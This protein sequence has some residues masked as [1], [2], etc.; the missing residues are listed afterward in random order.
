L[1]NQEEVNATLVKLNSILR[2]K[3]IYRIRNLD[4]FKWFY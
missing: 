1:T 4:C 2:F 3:P